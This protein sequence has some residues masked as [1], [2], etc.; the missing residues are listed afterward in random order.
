M[1]SYEFVYIISP[2][3]EQED[4]ESA[5]D[6]VGQMIVDRGGQVLLLESWGRRRLAYPIQKF[7]EG[8][9][10]V[11]QVQLEP[12]TISELKERLA[13]S[14]EVIRYLLVRTEDKAVEP[15]A[16]QPAE[17][18]LQEEPEEEPQQEEVE[19]EP[20]EEEV[21][22]EIQQEPVEKQEV[23]EDAE[24]GEAGG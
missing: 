15:L 1:R 18:P 5:T 12:G 16:A 22:E 21:E 14:E 8:Y 10:M 13:L 9:Y 2:E 11:A 24:E 7:H 4:L 17:E 3:I 23:A 19:E 20:E 6:K